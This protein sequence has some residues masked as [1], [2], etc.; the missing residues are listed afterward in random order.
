MQETVLKYACWFCHSIRWASV[1]T[2]IYQ[3]Q[4][5]KK[6][7]LLVSMCA[8]CALLPSQLRAEQTCETLKPRFSICENA[9]FSTDNINFFVAG[10]VCRHR[11]SGKSCPIHLLLLTFF[12]ILLN[13]V[14]SWSAHLQP[15]ETLPSHQHSRTT[16][17]NWVKDENVPLLFHVLCF[18]S[19]VVATTKSLTCFVQEGDVSSILS[20]LFEDFDFVVTRHVLFEKI[21]VKVLF[22]TPVI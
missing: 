5:Q 13:L 11:S 8:A 21:H 16:L 15:T 18:S 12:H 3:T 9:H 10:S 19:A 1:W 6:E 17:K 22:W 7:H 14:S 2:Q 4:W 20:Q